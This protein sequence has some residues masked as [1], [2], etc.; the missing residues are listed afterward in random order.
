MKRRPIL[1]SVVLILLVSA[2]ALAEKVY[3]NADLERMFGKS[4]TKP[5][6]ATTRAPSSAQLPD[7]LTWLQNRLADEKSHRGEIK[8]AEERVEVAQAIVDRLEQ[9]LAELRF[10]YDSTFRYRNRK[11]GTERLRY[12]QLTYRRML[13]K[14]EAAAEDLE[15][16]KLDLAEIKRDRPYGP[17]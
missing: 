2:P 14:F 1:L 15:L 12:R 10:A 16:A 5:T 9:E 6:P 17:N 13:Q 8:A 3:T 11:Q 7:P 4:T